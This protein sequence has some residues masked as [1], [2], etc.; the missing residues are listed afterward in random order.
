MDIQSVVAELRQEASRIDQAI[1][2]LVGLTNQ[3]VVVVLRRRFNLHLQR[4][5]RSVAG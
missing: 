3:H 4:V 1:A 5:S 2:A